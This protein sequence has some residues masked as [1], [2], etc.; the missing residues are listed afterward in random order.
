MFKNQA[1]HANNSKYG[2][3]DSNLSRNHA[4]IFDINETNYSSV[5]THGDKILDFLEKYENS[6]SF[7]YY[8]A[9]ENNHISS[10]KLLDGLKWMLKNEVKFVCISLSSKYY[11][12]DLQSWIL[13]NKDQITVYASYNNVINDLDYPAKYEGVIGIGSSL[14]I[15]KKKED[16]IYK[17][18]KIILISNGF[19]YFN[20]NSFLAPY[21]MLKST[22][23]NRLDK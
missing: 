20:G 6:Y 8:I 10:A 22:M 4:N 16:I 13:E 15:K 2:I 11:S 9:E 5:L 7:Y 1:T 12:E 3:I 14:K 19:Y 17:N 23:H 18:S 21:T